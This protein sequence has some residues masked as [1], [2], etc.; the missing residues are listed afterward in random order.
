MC[1]LKLVLGTV[2]TVRDCRIVVAALAIEEKGTLTWFLNERA[3][4]R[5]TQLGF[6]GR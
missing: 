6:F 5:E 1:A 4:K 2:S 3:G